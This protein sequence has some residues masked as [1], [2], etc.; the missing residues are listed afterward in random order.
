[1]GSWRG[2]VPLAR[3]AFSTAGTAG[4]AFCGP[5]GRAALSSRGLWR[6]AARGVRRE[7]GRA[8]VEAAPPA[9][10]GTPGPR[11][12]GGAKWLLYLLANLPSDSSDWRKRRGLTQLGELFL[13]N[14]FRSA[15]PPPPKGL[16]SRIQDGV[17]K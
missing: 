2:W 7:L 11:A 12:R 1:M 3:T 13:S 8:P 9:G 6:R 15:T 16:G 10:A 17:S 5:R 4:L 14:T